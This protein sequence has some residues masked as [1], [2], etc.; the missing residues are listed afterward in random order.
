[1]L[2]HRQTYGWAALLLAALALFLTASAAAEPSADLA[3][4]RL[5]RFG[6]GVNVTHWFMGGD[7][8]DSAA[9]AGAFPDG[10]L[11]AMQR[12][13]VGHVRLC[14]GP[15]TIGQPV[16]PERAKALVA[17]VERLRAHGLKCIV[18]IHG[19]DSD[20][21]E[22]PDGPAAL[23]A[24][25]KQLAPALAATDPESTFL[26]ILNE[27]VYRDRAADWIKLQAELIATIRAGAPKHTIVAT[28]DSWG[29]IDALVKLAP[30]SDRN[31]VYT[32]HFYEPHTFTHQSATWSWKPLAGLKGLEYPTN[33]RN[34]EALLA[35][36]EDKDLRW[37]LKRDCIDEPWDRARIAKRIGEAAAWGRKHGVPVH[38]GE[39]GVYPPGAP[40]T[41]RLNWLRDT[42][43]AL[44]REGI[45]RTAWGWDDIFTLGRR[46]E[47]GEL[48]Y[49][50][51]AAA[52]LGFDVVKEI[53]DAGKPAKEGKP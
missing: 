15:K 12:L 3:A 51:P 46:Q 25:W 44:D 19:W 9:L 17:A 30:Y 10:D 35:S 50:R 2:S 24:F 16:D 37:A 31:V 52:A 41:D 29:S 33:R 14:V 48:L 36:I 53:N 47:A 7:V 11:E 34:A 32:F 28:A 18:D 40:S 49:D 21:L 20:A 8:K 27:P 5:A 45:V 38:C 6:K 4:R 39:F 43:E 42:T 23:V 22:K 1:M 26:E 13:G